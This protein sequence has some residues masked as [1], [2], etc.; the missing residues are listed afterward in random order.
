[1]YI[2]KRIALFLCTGLFTYPVFAIDLLRDSD[3]EHAFAELSRPILQAAGLSPQRIKILLLK[4]K[5]PNAFIIDNKHIFV[6]S[7]LFLKT[8]KAEMFQ[9]IIA[10]EA[11]HIANGHITRRKNYM[12][13]AR[14]A[15][16]FG[17]A[18]AL[19]TGAVSRNH[20]LG[21]PLAIGASSSARGVLLSHTRAEE[22]AADQAAMRYLSRSNIDGAGML[23]VLNLFIDQ[24]NLSALRQDPYLRTHP[25]SRDRKRALEALIGA[26]KELSTDRKDAYWHERA[27]GKLSAF[28]NRPEWTLKSA[29]KSK[30]PDVRHLRRAIALSRQ[31]KVVSAL[32]EIEKAQA[33]RPNDPYLQELKAELLMRN[34]RFEQS[35]KEYEKA[36]SMKPNNALALSGY[37]RALLAD[38]QISKALS[39]LNK[40]RDADFRNTRLMRD[41]A[42]AYSKLGRNNMAALV[43]AERYALSGKIEDAKIHAQRASKG[44]PIG[45]PAWQRAQDVLDVKMIK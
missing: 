12:S 43:T 33:Q 31:G 36:V 14:T 11:A 3:I 24:E 4:D 44:L 6:S 16:A 30:N 1:M 21:L 23:D 17:I 42:L 27:L 41:L 13:V 29:D 39:V 9:S 18:L 45:S 32:D 35:A 20:E 28:I 25:S 8:D 5:R 19:T 40:A 2:M 34:K 26:K 10:H 38:G 15:S 7:G 22:S 37:G